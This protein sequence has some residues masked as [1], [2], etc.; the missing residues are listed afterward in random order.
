[1]LR[2]SG[3][4]PDGYL[5]RHIVHSDPE[6]GAGLEAS[7]TKMVERTKRTVAQMR[8]GSHR[9]V[10]APSQSRRS[11]GTPLP[12]S[13][14]GSCHRPAH[15]P[16]VRK[17]CWDSPSLST[18]SMPLV[19]CTTPHCTA[20]YG[21]SCKPCTAQHGES[22]RTLRVGTVYESAFS[23]QI[24]ISTDESTR[25]PGGVR[26]RRYATPIRAIRPVAT[27]L[28]ADR[29]GKPAR[30]ALRQTLAP[31]QGRLPRTRSHATP[32]ER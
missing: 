28:P 8:A 12:L 1:M 14:A 7:R 23:E 9:T 20:A 19:R 17:R 13:L 22:P 4:V 3:W 10:T 24:V 25:A 27:L 30:W 11:G 5:V 32:A 6:Q 29:L 31:D 16:G 2:V 26:P 15:S 21:L 18:C